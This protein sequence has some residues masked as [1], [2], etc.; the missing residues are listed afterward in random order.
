MTEIEMECQVRPEDSYLVVVLSPILDRLW[1][2]PRYAA[3]A[4]PGANPRSGEPII[5]QASADP[6]AMQVQRSRLEALLIVT[7]HAP[8][9]ALLQECGAPCHYRGRVNGA[10]QLVLTK[11][12]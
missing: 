2:A 4:N 10:G 7:P 8:L 3:W 5:V 1:G 9:Y 12:H 6:H 11:A